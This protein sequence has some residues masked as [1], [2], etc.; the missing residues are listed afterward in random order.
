[1]QSGL[2]ML[3]NE[4]QAELLWAYT[5]RL[6]A[7]LRAGAQI[8]TVEGA[9]GAGTQIGPLVAGSLAYAASEKTGKWCA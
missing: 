8:G 1:M 4:P 6:H 5:D 2:G 9:A 7:T 3:F